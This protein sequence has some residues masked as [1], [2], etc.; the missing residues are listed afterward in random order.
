MSSRRKFI[1]QLSLIG[2]GSQLDLKSF[3]ATPEFDTTDWKSVKKLFPKNPSQKINFNSGSAGTMPTHIVQELQRWIEIYNRVGLYKQHELNQTALTNAT[4]RMVEF[5]GCSKDELAIT[6]NTTES[7]NAIIWGIPLGKKDEVIISDCEY[8]YVTTALEQRF[9]REKFKLKKIDVLPSQHSDQEIIQTYKSALGK[10]TKLLVLTMITHREG[11]LLPVKELIDI[12][13][14]NGTEVLIDGAHV[15]GQYA[16]S[17][18]DLN[19]DYFGSCMH[20]WMNGPF[21]TG[22]LFSKSE[23]ISKLNSLAFPYPPR[24]QDSMQKFNY[25]GTIAFHNMAILDSV[26]EFNE[27]IGIQR[28]QK[29]LK[30]LNTCFTDQIR[31]IESINLVTDP[32]RSIA[33]SGIRINNKASQAIRKDLYKNEGLNIKLSSIGKK[34]IYRISMNLFHDESDIDKLVKALKRVSHE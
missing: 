21:G 4:E 16:F 26:M 24:L 17:L 34:S 8:P 12:A 9:K 28:K 11:Q 27:R 22:I 31:N 30:F 6:K 18:K 1:E 23:H 29:R 7:L 2:L 5:F 25:S 32:E 15:P 3:I 13:H 14:A 33:L 10:K 19:C 20:K